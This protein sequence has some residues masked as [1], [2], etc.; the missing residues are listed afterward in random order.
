QGLA[1]VI[2]VGGLTMLATATAA[3]LAVAGF[4]RAALA[5]GTPSRFALTLSLLLGGATVLWPYGTSFY[6]EAWQAATLTWAA[7]LLLE[8]RA[9]PA[10]AMRRVILASA[11][12]TVTGLTKVTSLVFV[13]GFIVAVLLAGSISTGRRMR[14]AIALATGISTAVV[15]HLVWNQY[16]FGSA[17]D[18]GYDWSETIPV[19][20]PQTFSLAEAPRGLAV[21]LASPGKSLFVWAPVLVLAA[22][23]GVRFWRRE[24]AVAV[25]ILTTFGLGLIFYAAY[26]FPE[27][28]YSHGPRHLVPIV[29]L[30]LL[31]ATGADAREWPR[32][33]ILACATLGA[34]VAILATAVSFLDDQAMSGD[35]RAPQRTSYYER[36]DPA[37]GRA[38][39]RYRLGYV[40]F[41]TATSTP[42]WVAA[43]VLGQGPDYHPLHLQQARR[44]LRDGQNIPAWFPWVWPAMWAA[45]LVVTARWLASNSR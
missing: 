28:G 27:G 10:T 34:T 26:L 11:L 14:S 7:A 22:L 31:L 25:G 20:P 8:A 5:L 23:S 4:Y 41:R 40:P 3:A 42:G 44:Q 9:A 32:A 16:R 24:P 36:I 30:L 2:L 33:A 39:N 6:T 35:A 1:W 43:P 37:S 21:L 38:I 12:L 17:F 45:V 15:I 29:P 18:F 19:L 13:P